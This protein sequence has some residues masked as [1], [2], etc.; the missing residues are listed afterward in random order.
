M[1]AGPF[2]NRLALFKRHDHSPAESIRVCTWRRPAAASGH[3]KPRRRYGTRPGGSCSFGT[4]K[5]VSHEVLSK[6]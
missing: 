4:R 5:V 6:R 1:I 3:L 2:G